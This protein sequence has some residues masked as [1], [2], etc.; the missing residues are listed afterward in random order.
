MKIIYH[1]DSDPGITRKKMS[2]GWGYFSPNGDRIT[3]RDE[4]DR[5][6]AIGLP[7]AYRDAWFCPKPNGHI[8]A[9]G[10]DEKGR[11]QYRYHLQFRERQETAKYDLCAAF[12]R[13]LPKLRARVDKDL[14]RR[15]LGKD[16]A[17]AAI[18]RLLDLGH[19]R[20]GNEGY[21]KENKS[22]GA[23]TLR[24][25]HAKLSGQTLKLQYK[26][27][28]G[29]LRMLTITDGSLSR[30]VKKCSDLNCQHLFS[31]VD[32]DGGC[33]PVTSSDVNEYIREAMGDDYTAKHFRTWS[34][35]AI[36][37]EAIATAD[38]DLGLKSMLEPV[39][40]ALG[41]TPAIARKS[42]VHPA[43]IALVKQ[44]QTKFRQGLTLP[45]KTQ[46]LS[47][48]ERGLI[49]FLDHA[50]PGHTAKAA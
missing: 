26:A 5:L 24:K 46:Y 13:D 18:V 8:Q 47:R 22:Y 21:V 42:Y 35:S 3:D 31:W 48:A 27:K 6:N 28:S 11:K 41:N 2:H 17:V 49:A 50:K 40:E 12:G 34:A 1:D 4:I 25:R 7:P 45:R 29:K 16:A 10:W 30:F 38:H 9:V 32:A 23:T 39:T 37:F 36:A 43:L 15:G 33:H 44:G 19:V 14:K 20:I